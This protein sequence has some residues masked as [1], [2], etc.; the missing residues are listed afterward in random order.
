MR[1]R[2]AGRRACGSDLGEFRPTPPSSSRKAKAA[3]GTS[4]APITAMFDNEL[5]LIQ[6]AVIVGFSYVV[7]LVFRKFGQPKVV[8]EMVAGIALGPTLF[9]LVA[10]NAYQ[11]L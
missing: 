8:G 10:P 6:I 9:G 4:T 5:F 3:G 2:S 11:A 7:S 1:S